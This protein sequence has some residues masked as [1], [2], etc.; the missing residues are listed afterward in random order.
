MLYIIQGRW[1]YII[2]NVNSPTDDKNNG[3]KDNSRVY[4][5]SQQVVDLFPK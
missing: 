5:E 1:D 3:T 2:L 4:E